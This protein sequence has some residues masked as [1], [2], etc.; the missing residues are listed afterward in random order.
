MITYRYFINRYRITLL[1]SLFF[2]LVT[3]SLPAVQQLQKESREK[4][5]MEILESIR[6]AQLQYRDDPTRGA[7]H[8]AINLDALAFPGAV[9]S[10]FE[11][12]EPAS[13]RFTCNDVLAR[14]EARNHTSVYKTVLILRY[15]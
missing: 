7:G 12:P 9:E 1:C 14:A 4:Q 2:I 15:E 5:A 8:F 3:I 6:S 10:F 13:Y 11:G